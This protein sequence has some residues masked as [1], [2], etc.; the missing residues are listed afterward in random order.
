MGVR[1]AFETI[2]VE[3]KEKGGEKDAKDGNECLFGE[4][5]IRKHVFKVGE[6][7]LIEDPE[8]WMED[9]NIFAVYLFH[10]ETRQSMEKGKV[11]EIQEAR[12]DEPKK[13][14]LENKHVPKI[15]ERSSQQVQ[16]ERQ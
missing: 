9:E 5:D 15:C 10:E 1:N 2:Q 8:V 13:G 7:C 6:K 14:E 4:E 16:G 11:G 12:Q 3:M